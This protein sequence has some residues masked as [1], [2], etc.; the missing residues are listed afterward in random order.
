[1]RADS[2][3]ASHIKR[4]ARP[5]EQLCRLR[6]RGLSEASILFSLKNPLWSDTLILIGLIL[7]VPT[8]SPVTEPVYTADYPRTFRDAAFIQAEFL[9]PDAFDSGTFLEEGNAAMRR[10]AESIS[11]YK[12]P[13][14]QAAA[15]VVRTGPYGSYPLILALHSLFFFLSLHTVY[16][17]CRS[18]IPTS[19][20]FQVVSRLYTATCAR[21]TTV[22]PGSHLH[23]SDLQREHHH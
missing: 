14:Y 11:Q 18:R 4:L 21:H 2:G 9:H 15:V 5:L 19:G 7:R 22:P 20:L 3:C 12:L 17:P 13:T 1:M 23:C 8:M 16:S 6:P 10:R